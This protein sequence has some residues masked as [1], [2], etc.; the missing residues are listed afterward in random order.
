[1]NGGTYANIFGFKKNK[2]YITATV[3]TYPSLRAS[4]ITGAYPR[5]YVH[6]QIRSSSTTSKDSKL[7]IAD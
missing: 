5:T 7:K 6:V 1:M 4:S 3:K 2:T